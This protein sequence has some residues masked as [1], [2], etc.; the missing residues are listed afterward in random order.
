MRYDAV[1][2]RRYSLVFFGLLGAIAMP[3]LAQDP[4]AGGNSST[5]KPTEAKENTPK[6]PIVV[7]SLNGV[8]TSSWTELNNRVTVV[9]SGLHDWSST[10]KND[11]GDLRLFL[12]GRMLP[13][14]EPAMINRTQNYVTFLL[15]IVPPYRVLLFNVFSYP[16][17]PHPHTLP[18]TVRAKTPK[19]P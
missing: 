1:M 11:P 4:Q 3:L 5:V 16:P 2:L 6:D 10:G 12:A 17:K 13:K 14:A 19:K 18:T 15:D 7:Q 8:K 9:V